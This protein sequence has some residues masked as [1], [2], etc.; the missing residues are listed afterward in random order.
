MSRPL[1]ALRPGAALL[2]LGLASAPVRAGGEGFSFRYEPSY[3]ASDTTTTF[4]SGAEA[5]SRAS[6]L[7]QRYTLTFDKNLFPT[8]RFGVNGNYEW[9]LGSVESA[10]AP[11]SES[12]SRQWILDARLTAGSPI[13]YGVVFYDQGRRSARSMTG[14]L[15]A[16]SPTLLNEVIGFN[17]VWRP[18]DFPDAQLLLTRDR[19]HDEDRRLSDVVTDTAQLVLHYAPDPSLDLRARLLYSGSEDQ[20]NGLK[21]STFGEQI[22]AAWSSD[23]ADRRISAYAHYLLNATQIDSTV[24]GPGGSILV[25][26]YPLTGLST[27]E[28][29]PPAETP[30]KVTLRPNQRLADGDTAASAGLDIG[31]GVGPADTAYRDVGAQFTD[32]VT[33]VSLVYVWVDKPLPAAVAGAFTWQA[34]RSDDNLNWT[35]LPLAGPVTFALF[36]NRFEIPIPVTQ[37]KYLKLVSRPLPVGVTFEEQYRSI[38]I[39]EVQFYEAI[40]AGA[41]RS[42]SSLNGQAS[43]STRVQLIRSRLIYDLGLSLQ[44]SDVRSPLWNV[45]NGLRYNQRLSRV[46]DLSALA[47][48]NDGNSG[49]GSHL[50]S[51]RWSASI[52]ADPLPA[53]GATVAYLGEWDQGAVGETTSNSLSLSARATPYQ[54]VSLFGVAT[55]TLASGTHT[56][57]QKSDTVT[58]GVSVAP[59]PRLSFTGSYMNAFSVQS[60]QGQPTTAST[61]RRVEGSASWNPV[62][63]LSAS[64]GISYGEVAGVGQTLVNLSGSLSPFPGGDLVLSFRYSQSI[65]S[66]SGSKTIIFGP[67]LRWNIRSGLFAEGT[68]TWVDVAQPTQDAASRVLSVRLAVRL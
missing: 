22:R 40:A 51:T 28:A 34:Y 43:V 25:Q 21:S 5:R 10:N 42:F 27:V 17:A 46:F 48:R 67:Y 55:R 2:L 9:G 37:A 60:G 4:P 64:G 49:G 32:A 47:E 59:N 7:L 31:F 15:T 63:A 54:D 23:W 18:D 11:P 52:T 19:L 38:L 56:R 13:L 50:A 41:G 39:T 68:Y 66:L 33:P 44:H 8:L 20:L 24:T 14:G 1:P 58:A 12:D 16:E 3:D 29:P 57:T 6:V 53:L 26:R 45:T 65:D 62:P 30:T 61:T 36:Q 35:A